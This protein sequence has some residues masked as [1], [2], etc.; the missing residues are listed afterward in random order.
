MTAYEPGQIAVATVRGVPN[1]RVMRGD[2]IFKN[3]WYSNRPVTGSLTSFSDREVTD[4]HPL[5][6]LDLEK[7]SEPAIADL[8]RQLR[9]DRWHLVADQ[10]EAQIKPPKPAEPTGLGAV[11]EDADGNRWVRAFSLRLAWTDTLFA[12]NCREYAD[13]DAVKVL[14]EGVQP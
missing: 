9:R 12:E 3:N 13:I 8:V 1:V 14:S 7:H 4:I 2:G 5:V 10:I 11:V 6:V